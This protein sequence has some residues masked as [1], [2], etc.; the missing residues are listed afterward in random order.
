[1]SP[2][3]VHHFISLSDYLNTFLVSAIVMIEESMGIIPEDLCR[4]RRMYSLHV[5]LV[6]KSVSERKFKERLS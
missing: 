1:V 6:F 5:G 2:Y 4:P 3:I